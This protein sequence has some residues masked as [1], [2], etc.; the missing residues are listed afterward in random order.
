MSFRRSWRG[1]NNAR[2]G[3]P[4]RGWSIASS[5]AGRELHTSP[6]KGAARGRSTAF[7]PALRR[8]KCCRVGVRHR[9]LAFHEFSRSR[10]DPH[11]APPDQVGGRRPPPFW[12][13]YCGACCTAESMCDSPADR[14]GASEG[15]LRSRPQPAMTC[16]RSAVISGS[17]ASFSAC[18]WPSGDIFFQVLARIR[19]SFS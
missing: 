16:C 11:P 15:T 6:C 10:V 12:G 14:R 13:R 18:S 2:S 1:A 3:Q 19:A 8:G 9:A 17:N 4:D 5:V 7:A